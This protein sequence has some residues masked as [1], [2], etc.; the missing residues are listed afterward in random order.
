MGAILTYLLLASLITLVDYQQNS[1]KLVLNFQERFNNAW[2]I[3]PTGAC[4]DSLL[5]LLSN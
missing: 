5:I 1:I 2:E 4:A 3:V